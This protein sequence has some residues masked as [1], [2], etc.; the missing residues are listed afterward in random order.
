MSLSTTQKWLLSKKSFSEEL[1]LGG[2]K[3]SK[4]AKKISITSGK[5]GV[6]KTSVSVKIG[7]LLAESGFRVL[8]LD[9]DYNLSNTHVKLG[10]PITNNFQQLIRAEKEF[11][12]CIYKEG[13]FH[14]LSAANGDLDF[15]DSGLELDKYITD[16]ITEHENEYDYILLDCPAGLSKSSVTLNA[17]CDYRIIVVTPDKSSI[18]DSYSLI[19]ILNKKYEIYENH[20]LVNKVSSES[21]FKRIVNTLSQTVENFLNSRLKVLG[22]IPK[23]HGAVDAFDRVLMENFSGELHRGFTKVA[24]KIAEQSEVP[25]VGT[26]ACVDDFGQDVQPTAS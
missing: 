22:D 23:V 15:F 10:I 9:C 18:T 11:D 7:K 5:G 8:L 19:K 24:K 1:L 25:R 17:Y 20:L 13:N 3:S 2:V 16:I 4:T 21:Q 26:Y 12:E 14:L 6:G